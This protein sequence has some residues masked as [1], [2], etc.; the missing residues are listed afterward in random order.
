MLS[1]MGLPEIIFMFILLLTITTLLLL[2]AL[3]TLLYDSHVL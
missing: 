1:R 3:N 2:W